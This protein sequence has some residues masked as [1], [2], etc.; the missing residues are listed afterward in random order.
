MIKN[1]SFITLFLLL[2]SAHAQTVSDV[3]IK[4]FNHLEIGLTMGTTGIGL[5]LT[6]PI[7]N[8]IQVRTGFDFMPHFSKVVNFGVQVGDTIE[9]KYD[10]NG[11]R[12]ETKFDRMAGYLKD[13]TGNEVDDNIDMKGHPTLSNFKLLVDVLPF[14]NKNWHI[15]AG[16]YVGSA[17]VGR[18]INTMEDMTTL[19]AVNLYNNI[20]YKTI[21]PNNND[22]IF[23][24][25]D[26]PPAIATKI[27]NAGPMQIHMGDKVSDGTPYMMK[28]NEKNLVTC[29]IK[30]NNFKPYLGFGYGNALTKDKKYNY[31]FD[32]GLLFWG[33]TPKIITHDGTDIANDVK[34]IDGKVGDYVKLIKA[35][36]VYPAINFRL[37]RKLF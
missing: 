1:L 9:S 30:V 32:C 10:A 27:E 20:Y 37:T 11:N 13:M 16:F 17:V 14:K 24:G 19:M 33:G 31:S 4:A 6:S 2:I 21:D 25:I 3:R 29:K 7:N 36:K 28:P 8:S 22:G 18:A 12:I 5:E 35:F 26:L 15:T 23:M 34:N